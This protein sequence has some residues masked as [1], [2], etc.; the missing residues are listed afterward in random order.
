M[1]KTDKN[2][3]R[4]FLKRS[5]FLGGAGVA[6]VAL[7]GSLDS[8]ALGQPPPSAVSVVNQ[9]EMLLTASCIVFG[10]SGGSYSVKDTGIGPDLGGMIVDVSQITDYGASL[11]AGVSGA[12]T[13]TGGIQEAISCLPNGGLILIQ[14]GTYNFSTGIYIGVNGIHIFGAGRDITVLNFTGNVNNYHGIFASA[15]AANA[16]D[17]NATV[18]LPMTDLVLADFSVN[19]N[20][21]LASFNSNETSGSCI[22][23]V[24]TQGGLFSRLNLYGM[25]TYGLHIH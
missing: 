10:D 25:A 6:G 20:S 24:A 3:R 21:T 16:T 7:M 9:W 18:S 4:E 13:T 12:S 23:T 2:V 22:K 17:T 19:L 11:G 5:A 14:V 8:N 15:G 1:S